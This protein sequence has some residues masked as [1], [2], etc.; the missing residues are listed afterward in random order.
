MCTI[1]VNVVWGRSYEIV[2]I[3]VGLAGLEHSKSKLIM[4]RRD[5]LHDLRLI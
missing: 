2:L 3:R 4:T 5:M 1:N